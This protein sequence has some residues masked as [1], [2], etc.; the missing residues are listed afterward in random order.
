MVRHRLLCVFVCVAL[1]ALAW[2]FRI[3]SEREARAS[4]SCLLTQCAIAGAASLAYREA[5]GSLLPRA[6][7]RVGFSL[8]TDGRISNAHGQPRLS[9]RLCRALEERLRRELGRDGV[10]LVTCPSALA[11]VAPTSS[12]V[13]AWVA[14]HREE[15]HYS[16]VLDGASGVAVKCLFRPEGV[17]RPHP[18]RTA[19]LE[20][21]RHLPVR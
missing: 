20:E 4:T 15:T 11:E 1:L 9:A 16:V 3:A 12:A 7:E 19:L 8:S 2:R 10:S 17:Q 21:L 6:G 18:G 5:F 14:Q 13:L